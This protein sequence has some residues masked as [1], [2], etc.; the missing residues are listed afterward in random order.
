M[1]WLKSDL[2]RQFVRRL[3][4]RSWRFFL[5]GLLLGSLVTTT[6]CYSRPTAPPLE[7]DADAVEALR[8][9]IEAVDWDE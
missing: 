9:Q 2:R 5:L 1:Q 3:H 4:Y 8:H 6:G 7:F